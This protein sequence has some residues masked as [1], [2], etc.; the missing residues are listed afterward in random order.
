M[1]HSDESYYDLLGVEPTA[2]TEEIKRAFRQRAL[3]LH[4]DHN[5]SSEAHAQFMALNQAYQTLIDPLQRRHYDMQRHWKQPPREPMPW[6][7][8]PAYQASV[9]PEPPPYQ[10]AQTDFTEA[11]WRAKASQRRR[12]RE[13]YATYVPGFRWAAVGMLLFSLL[14][15]FEYLFQQR[16]GPWVIRE[17]SATIHHG[18]GMT[19]V[20]TDDPS[21][22]LAGEMLPL[23]EPGD[24]LYCW[25]TPLLGLEVKVQVDLKW[26]PSRQRRI[27][28]L[29]NKLQLPDLNTPFHPRP[30]IFNLFAPVWIVM[31]LLAI[32]LLMVPR[33]MPERLFQ[34]GLLSSFFGLLTVFL[35]LIS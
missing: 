1:A 21:L 13:E 22:I 33:R 20:R 14:L 24:F 26:T 11:Y 23:L 10:Q 27:P 8:P 34:V 5:P 29:A 28:R 18:R 15:G 12:R 16:E 32:A 31:T 7:P 19:L 35:T 4:P 25:R 2:S 17:V 6:T 3:H 30:G 9:E